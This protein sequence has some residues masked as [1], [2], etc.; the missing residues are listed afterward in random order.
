MNPLAPFNINRI[1][2][3]AMVALLS[4]CGGGSAEQAATLAPAVA[5]SPAAS[6][7]PAPAEAPSPASA[8]TVLADVPVPPVS[9]APPCAPDTCV[10][11]PHDELAASSGSPDVPDAQGYLVPATDVTATAGEPLYPDLRMLPTRIMPFEPIVFGDVS[12]VAV[13]SVR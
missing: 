2:C 9:A 10:V 6:P 8:G 12:L 11:T 4:A 3:Y 5:T 13:T 7:V 1:A